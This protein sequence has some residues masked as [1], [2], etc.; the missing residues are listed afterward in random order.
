MTLCWVIY[1]IWSTIGFVWVVSRSHSPASAWGWCGAM[2]ICPPL[3]TL[4]Y[5]LVAD[6]RPRPSEVK[7]HPSYSRLQNAIA[8]GCG[9]TLTM[10]NTVTSLHNADRTFATLIRDLQR[11]QREICIEYYILSNDRIANVIFDIL[12]R[13]AHAGVKVRIIYD[14]IGSW[15]LKRSH[16]KALRES[17]VDIRP[18]GELKFPY[19]TPSVHRRNHRKLVI[20]DAQTIYLGGINIAGRYLGKG[21]LGYWRDEHIKIEGSVVQ[22]AQAL[23]LAGWTRCGGKPFTPYQPLRIVRTACPVQLVWAEEGASRNALESAILEAIATAR[24]NIRISTPYFL[25]TRAILAALCSAARGG[26]SVEL[27]VPQRADVKVIALA[28]EGFIRQC[29]EAGVK[30]YRYRNG[31]LHSKTITIDDSIT[32]VGSANID[33]RSMR[34]NLELS[35]VIY[36]RATTADYVSRFYAD[37]AMAERVTPRRPTAWLQIKQGFVRLLAPIL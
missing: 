23:F 5:L 1:A 33:Y 7:I 17:G 4:L 9:A 27:L 14:A 8:N 10:S 34:Y 20:I 2:I 6:G 32:I 28:A 12:C 25:P 26:V 18:Y 29:A 3:A 16:I 22:Q 11:A 36:N 21:K 15:Q 35:A 30:V 31:F 24:H 19:L 37:V 13:R